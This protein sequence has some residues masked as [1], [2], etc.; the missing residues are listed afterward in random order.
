MSLHFSEFWIIVLTWLDRCTCGQ[1]FCYGCGQ[2]RDF[3]HTCPAYYNDN[4][5]GDDD[6]A[7]EAI[8]L[9]RYSH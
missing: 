9:R 8:D 5:N 6:D 1:T 7:D 4:D 3:D 2:P